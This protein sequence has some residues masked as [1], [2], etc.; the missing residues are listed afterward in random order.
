MRRKI[1]G[2]FVCTLLIATALPVMGSYS[3]APNRNNIFSFN[4][5]LDGGWLEEIDGVKV[6]HL[7]GSKNLSTL[8]VGCVKL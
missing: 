8:E 5:P 7:N 6:L 1:L 4:N 3:E 2:I